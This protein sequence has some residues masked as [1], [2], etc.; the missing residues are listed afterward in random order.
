MTK[1]D[2]IKFARLFSEYNQ[3]RINGKASTFLEVIESIC[4]IFQEDNSN[5]D[6]AR[7]I[8]VVLTGKGF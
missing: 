5:F 7:F 4:D 2:Y 1:K 6:R 8:N 3:N